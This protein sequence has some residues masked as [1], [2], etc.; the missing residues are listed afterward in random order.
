MTTK[1]L[2]I[3]NLTAILAFCMSYHLQSQSH[4]IATERKYDY[5]LQAGIIVPDIISRPHNIK[6]LPDSI[7]ASSLIGYQYLEFYAQFVLPYE[8]YLS[9][10]YDQGNNDAPRSVLFKYLKGNKIAFILDADGDGNFLEEKVDTVPVNKPTLTIRA[11]LLTKNG[12]PCPFMLPLEINVNYQGEIFQSMSIRNLLKYQIK[13]PLGQ[14]TLLVDIRAHQLNMQCYL[15]LHTPKD[16]II[17]FRLNEPF[18]FKGLYYRLTN[19]NLCDNTVTLERLESDKIRG[20]KEGF[21]LDMVMLRQLTEKH[22]MKGSTIPWGDKPYTLLHFWG[23][24][25]DP[26]RA[27]TPEVNA[28]DEHLK[29][30]KQVQM[31]HYPFVFKKELLG[32]TLSYIQENKL[33]PLQSLCISGNCA[34][35]ESEKEQCDVCSFA[36]VSDFPKYILLD[37]QGKILFLNKQGGAQVAINKLK[38]L[39]LY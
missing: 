4:V 34:V 29:T 11:L 13:Y 39:G 26:C 1:T 31:V 8:S 37:Q 19:L 15:N 30:G 27:E 23:E 9:P 28:L 16:S 3:S 36:R 38:V 7:S 24:W 12:Q 10:F 21:Y 6:N 14:D 32:R 18:L 35:D 17:R 22:L 33:S 25:C 2:V 5:P 20:Y